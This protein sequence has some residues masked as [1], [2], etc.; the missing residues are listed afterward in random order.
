[1]DSRW[2]ISDEKSK[3]EESVL[4]SLGLDKIANEAR[5]NGFI[6]L[7]HLYLIM[8]QGESYGGG[9]CE[10]W[11]FFQCGRRTASKINAGSEQ[12][13]IKLWF[14]LVHRWCG[15][16]LYG[17]GVEAIELLPVFKNT[18]EGLQKVI[19]IGHEEGPYYVMLKDLEEYLEGIQR[20]HKIKLPIPRIL[21]PKTSK[22][23]RDAKV[24][25]DFNNADKF[26]KSVRLAYEDGSTITIQLPQKPAKPVTYTTLG[27]RDMGK[28]WKAFIQV[29]Q[30]PF[31]PT[32]DLGYAWKN[33]KIKSDRVKHYD[34]SRKLLLEINKRLLN[35][36]K[37][38]YEIQIPVGYKL[39]EQRPSDRPGIYRFKFCVG[40]TKETTD[41]LLPKN[42][43]AN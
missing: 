2:R 8:A 25:K 14:D 37:N 38:A 10:L 13:R 20:E 35:F 23:T 7:D 17:D 16:A 33:G 5:R 34:A 3:S 32:Y 9:L 21:F 43:H 18:M 1:M 42:N 24:E 15:F 12:T 4:N 31:N 36:F 22:N 27:F 19:Y 26:I 41:Q 28:T 11:K 29:L 40:A 6:A 39:Y 30:D